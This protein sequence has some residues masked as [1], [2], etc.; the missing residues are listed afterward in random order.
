MS[1]NPIYETEF[2]END[3]DENAKNMDFY[4]KLRIRVNTFLAKHPNAR[5]AGFLAAVPDLFYLMVRLM[6]DKRVPIGAKAKLAGAVSYFVLPIDIVPDFVPMAGLLD[7]LI[8][9]VTLL[10]RALDEIDP[11]VVDEHWMGEGQVYD[12]IKSVLDKGDKLVGTKAWNAIRRVF[13][14]K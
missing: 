4:K 9:S 2:V 1:E 8:V 14:K 6:G 5:F 11:A 12:F 3:S 10:N 13:G 7:D